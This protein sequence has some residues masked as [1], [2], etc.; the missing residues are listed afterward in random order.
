MLGHVQ[1]GRLDVGLHPDPPHALH[2]PQRRERSREGERADGDEPDRL[3]A[4][5]VEGAAVDEAR[6]PG[7][8]V[9][10]QDRNGEEAGRERPPDA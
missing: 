3:D 4:E 7:G 6:R 2:H 8:E 5:L 9:L 1:S 10:R